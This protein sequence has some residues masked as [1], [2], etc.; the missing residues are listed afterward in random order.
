[1]TPIRFWLRVIG[2]RFMLNYKLM[3]S[4][5]V[6]SYVSPCYH[7]CLFHHHPFQRSIQSPNCNPSQCDRIKKTSNPFSLSS[8]SNN[9]C[10]FLFKVMTTHS[11]TAEYE[12]SCYGAKFGSVFALTS[13]V[14]RVRPPKSNTCWAERC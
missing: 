9:L 6:E 8:F 1:V 10:T 2:F 4:R 14:T 13:H 11:K 12:S 3:C 5:G 7:S